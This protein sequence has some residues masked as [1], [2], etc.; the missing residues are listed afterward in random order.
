MNGL[1]AR[2][3]SALNFGLRHPGSIYYR[4]KVLCSSAT[5]LTLT[6]PLSPYEYRWYWQTVK[7]ILGNIR[8]ESVTLD[9]IVSRKEEV[10]MFAVASC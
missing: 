9:R 7:E 5:K 6:V 1:S 10:A 8:G 4:A 3:G 2:A